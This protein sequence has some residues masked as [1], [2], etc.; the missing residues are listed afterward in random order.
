[1]RMQVS[2]SATV[3]ISTCGVTKSGTI[4]AGDGGAKRALSANNIAIVLVMAAS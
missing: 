2:A 3:A 1:V 4:I